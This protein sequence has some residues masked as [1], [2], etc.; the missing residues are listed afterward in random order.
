[1]C[2]CVFWQLIGGEAAYAYA[3]VCYGQLIGGK[4]VHAYACVFVVAADW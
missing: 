3:G 2:V 4:V 1:M